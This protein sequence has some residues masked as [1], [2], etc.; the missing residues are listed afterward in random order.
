[1]ARGSVFR[2]QQAMNGAV[3]LERQAGQ[4]QGSQRHCGHHPARRPLQAAQQAC[5]QRT[6]GIAEGISGMAE[7]HQLQVALILQRGDT[8]VHQHIG[9][10]GG[11]PAAHHRQRK[12]PEHGRLARQH[13]GKRHQQGRYRQRHP[14]Q[15]RADARGQQH[16]GHGGNGR[17]Q[18][19]QAKA[20]LIHTEHGLQ[21]GQHRRE[22][23]P[24]NAHRGKGSDRRTGDGEC[25]K[26]THRDRPCICLPDLDR[27]GIRS[28]GNSGYFGL[29]LLANRLYSP[30]VASHTLGGRRTYLWRTSNGW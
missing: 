8:G 18:D 19:Q 5:A 26:E 16:G 14:A 15:P 23:A 21:I 12:Q 4:H 13:E 17:E 24:E 2:A 3:L 1:M 29:P 20:R 27:R 28:K 25:G 22:G 11:G 7:V 9:Q 10:A 30:P 6:T